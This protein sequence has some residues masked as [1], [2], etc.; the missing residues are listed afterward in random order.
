MY[1]SITIF[2]LSLLLVGSSVHFHSSYD[3]GK[4]DQGMCD[5]GCNNKQHKTSSHECD[6]C[7]NEE[8][9]RTTF[10][11]TSR[12]LLDISESP[13][14]LAKTNSTAGFLLVELYGRAPP[15]LL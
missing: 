12:S 1:K 7:L 13:L 9:H 6:R 5:V 10:E 4:S 14:F 3:I 15:N 8:T 11:E 2:V